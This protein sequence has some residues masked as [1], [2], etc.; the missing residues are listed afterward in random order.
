MI[1]QF[2]GK[3]EVT[4]TS[5]HVNLSFK[6]PSR[7]EVAR[8]LFHLAVY[9]I[10]LFLFFGPGVVLDRLAAFHFQLRRGRV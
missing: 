2:S 4:N 10:Y 6:I 8:R 9:S 7:Q 1:D 3:E 5:N